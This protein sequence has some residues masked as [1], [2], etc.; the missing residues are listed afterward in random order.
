[1]QKNVANQKVAIYAHDTIS[2][3]AKTGDAANLM[4]YIS[5]D[6]ASPV[7]SND[8][9]PVELDSTNMPGVYVFDLTQAET[10]CDSFML[11]AK[12]STTGVQCDI[13]KLQTSPGNYTALVIDANGMVKLASDGLDAVSVS[14]PSGDPVG[15]NFRQLFMWVIAR[16]KNKHDKDSTNNEINVYNSSDSKITKQSY[17]A[18]GGDETVNKIAQP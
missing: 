17:T 15:W 10:N 6:E 12:S 8:V 9:N 13:I 5:K 18:V 14:E 1:M 16:F 3:I 4:A 7:Q 2:D 11:Y